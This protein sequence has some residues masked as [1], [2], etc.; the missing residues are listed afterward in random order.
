M[1]RGAYCHSTHAATLLDLVC[2]APYLH[3]D[4]RPKCVLD[5]VFKWITRTWC[6]GCRHCMQICAS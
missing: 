3:E 5:G 1:M 6:A 2:V 4:T